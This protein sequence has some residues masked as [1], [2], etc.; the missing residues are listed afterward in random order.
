MEAYNQKK[1]LK[2]QGE[3]DSLDGVRDTG[4]PAGSHAMCKSPPA[5]PCNCMELRQLPLIPCLTL[6]HP[7][8]QVTPPEQEEIDPCPNTDPIVDLSTCSTWCM[9][10]GVVYQA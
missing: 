4:N 6:N 3:S 8:A 5:A 9:M 7:A 1:A 10:K 2:R